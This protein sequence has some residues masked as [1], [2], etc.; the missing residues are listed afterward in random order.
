M[1]LLGW[2]VATCSGISLCAASVTGMITFW[3]GTFEAS[4]WQTYLI[5]L[6]IAVLTGESYLL[7]SP[8]NRKL[9]NWNA[10]RPAVPISKVDP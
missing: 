2:W 9:S 1:S 6:A 10:S 7:V 4:G 8:I 5:Y 3:N